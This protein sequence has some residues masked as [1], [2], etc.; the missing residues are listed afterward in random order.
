[1][2][3]FW[4][5]TILRDGIL[6]TRPQVNKGAYCETQAGLIVFRLWPTSSSSVGLW[7][8]SNVFFFF[9]SALGP[10]NKISSF[11]LATCFFIYFC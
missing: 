3:T 9:F 4:N 2:T 11:C 6:K 8:L 1:M 5:K 10:K 7:P